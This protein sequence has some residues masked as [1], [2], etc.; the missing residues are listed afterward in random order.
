[1]SAGKPPATQAVAMGTINPAPVQRCAPAE[2]AA[3]RQ[4]C[5]YT[6]HRKH[7]AG[8]SRLNADKQPYRAAGLGPSQ[9]HQFAD[10]QPVAIPEPTGRV[11]FLDH[12]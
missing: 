6:G 1:M 9:L 8:R 2:Y 10:I 7:S 11:S 4:S 5:R 3:H 12:H